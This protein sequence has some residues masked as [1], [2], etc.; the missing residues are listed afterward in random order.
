M[1][2][3]D[4]DQNP[5]RSGLH[6]LR[7]RLIPDRITDNHRNRRVPAEL[8]NRELRNLCGLEANRPDRA[9]NKEELRARLDCGLGGLL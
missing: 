2:R 5:C 6:Q 4:P 1:A 7:C 9:L 8:R 3:A